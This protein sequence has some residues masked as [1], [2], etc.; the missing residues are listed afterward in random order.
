V[1]VPAAAGRPKPAGPP[2]ATVA[3]KPASRYAPPKRPAYPG[4]IPAESAMSAA[5]RVP[6]APERPVLTHSKSGS[7]S[8]PVLKDA[9][10]AIAAIEPN[11]VPDP[12]IAAP[13]DNEAGAESE[14]FDGPTVNELAKLYAPQAPAAASAP[15]Q[16]RPEPPAAVRN[17]SPYAPER[18]GKH[19]AARPGSSV[20]FA[21]E[22]RPR[23]VRRAVT[24]TAR[25]GDSGKPR[26][27]RW[28]ARNAGPAAS[29]RPPRGGNWTAKAAV[30]F[31]LVGL[32]GGAGAVVTFESLTPA[33]PGPSVAAADRLPPDGAPAADAAAGQNPPASNL[34]VAAGVPDPGVEVVRADDAGNGLAP[35]DGVP[36][37]SSAKMIPLPQPVQTGARLRPT[38]EPASA[39]GAGSL[40][41]T[42]TSD[43]EAAPPADTGAGATEAA[44]GEPAS[45]GRDVTADGGDVPAGPAPRAPTPRP[46]HDGAAAAGALAYAPTADPIDR[47]AKAFADKGEDKTAAKAPLAGSARVVSWVNMRAS[48]DN[49]AATVKVLPTGSLVT[50]VQC[51]Y[52]CEIV[53]DGKRGFIFKK[54]LKSAGG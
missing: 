28:Q 17:A 22:P 4:A 38:K 37:P 8:S 48:A 54:F 23:P 1:P 19:G 11:E 16:V 6:A 35:A 32:I 14:F 5:P 51:S 43:A 27:I 39:R 24:A 36:L 20:I 13:S 42:E 30:A 33:E 3:A 34:T 15:P 53:A 26:P 10:E 49:N 41:A 2:P 47:G 50:V 12:S 25:P 45:E 44:S 46:E 40:D 21:S 31:V 9:A 7:E 29:Q 52:W 18:T